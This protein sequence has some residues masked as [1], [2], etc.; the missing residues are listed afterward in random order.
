MRMRLVAPL[1]STHLHFSYGIRPEAQ[2]KTNGVIFIITATKTTGSPEVQLFTQTLKPQTV[3]GDRPQHYTD[4]P[5]PA[6][7]T[8]ITFETRPA[9]TVNYDWS[10]WSD[11]RFN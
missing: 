3:P 7:C 5:L 10:Y 2:D 1:G 6:G 9:T 11:V 4:I 8:Q